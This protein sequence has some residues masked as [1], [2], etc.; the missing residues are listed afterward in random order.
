MKLCSDGHIE[1]CYD[2]KGWKNEP[3]P[4]CEKINDL[5][6]IQNKLDDV[7]EELASANRT[8]DDLEKVQ[9]NMDNI[10]L[11]LAAINSDN[12]TLIKR[13]EKLE[14]ENAA[15]KNEVAELTKQLYDE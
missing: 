13:N 6:N 10:N 2:E 3:C 5:Q 15:L 11:E 8:I 12:D 1:I 9:D 14:E 4:L 7:I